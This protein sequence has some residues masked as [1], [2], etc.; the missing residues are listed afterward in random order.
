MSL[1]EM[2]SSAYV[3]FGDNNTSADRQKGYTK[4]AGN[5]RRCFLFAFPPVEAIGEHLGSTS[6]NVNHDYLTRFSSR[7]KLC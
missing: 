3:F 4:N 2:E 1:I 5:A 7:N 6:V